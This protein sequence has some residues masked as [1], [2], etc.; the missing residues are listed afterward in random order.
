MFLID[1]N[2]ISEA[3]KQTRANIGVTEFF[4]N[5]ADTGDALYLSVIA[6]GE[7]RRGVELIRHRGDAAQAQRLD[8]WL[9]VVIDQYREMI[10]SFDSDAAQVWGRLRV[11]NPE[12]ELDKQVAAIALVNGL[13]I[14]TRK[15]MH[16]QG[17]G[18]TV[19]NPFQ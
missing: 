17:T 13:T 11:P 2:V 4:T 7:L 16:F 18:A 5:A 8:E 19:R 15:V 14:V 10:L 1:T 12:H 9:S 6:I 3:R